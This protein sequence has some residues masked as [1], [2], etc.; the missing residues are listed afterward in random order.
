MAVTLNSIKAN[1]TASGSYSVSLKQSA[2]GTK[3][4]SI[5]VIHN[6]NGSVTLQLKNSDGTVVQQVT[7]PSAQVV[8]PYAVR[9]VLTKAGTG[10]DVSAQ[11]RFAA[12]WT[13]F[14]A[15][16]LNALPEVSI[17]V[18]LSQTANNAQ[19]LS[20]VSPSLT[21]EPWDHL[22]PLEMP[23]TTPE[24]AKARIVRVSRPIEM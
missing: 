20:Y 24:D 11:H 12:D 10:W 14:G 3:L 23:G 15:T 9:L 5:G 2:N 19:E 13:P 18:A 8:T 6:A 7:V 4:V 17:N 16:T 1:F 22:F 21:S